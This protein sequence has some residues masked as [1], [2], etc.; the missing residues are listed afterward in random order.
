MKNILSLLTTA[1]LAIS[2]VH[3][4][5]GSGFSYMPE[6]G[7]YNRVDGFRF[8]LT[9]SNEIFSAVEASATYTYAA[10]GITMVPLRSI[11]R[12][13]GTGNLPLDGA[14]RALPLNLPLPAAL[15]LLWAPCCSA[16]ITMII[17]NSGP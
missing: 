9:V 1:V 7:T 5:S 14:M 6:L 2:L 16:R 17:I 8:G 12:P 11:T 10:V 4:Q 3:G 13:T 15:Q